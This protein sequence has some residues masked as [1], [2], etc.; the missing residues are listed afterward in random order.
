MYIIEVKQGN[1]NIA[2]VQA[3]IQ[4]CIDA[5]VRFLPH[6]DRDF[7]MIPLLCAGSFHGIVNRALLSYRVTISGR[8]T[9]IQKR[10]HSESIN[11]L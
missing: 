3:K 8:R 9:L 11:D 4:T 5:M 7:R 6:A 10:R 2:E 1:P